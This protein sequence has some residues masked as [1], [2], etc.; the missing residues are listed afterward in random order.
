[1]F[2]NNNEELVSVVSKK[3]NI[4]SVLCTVLTTRYFD[5]QSVMHFITLFQSVSISYH[6]IL[7]K[8]TWLQVEYD[9]DDR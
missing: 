5:G 8:E 9:L 2:L 3:L 1:M 7:L 6:I 4:C